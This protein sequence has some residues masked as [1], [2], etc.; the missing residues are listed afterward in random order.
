VLQLQDN[1]H[2]IVQVNLTDMDIV[3]KAM[4]ANTI[5]ITELIH[6][7]LGRNTLTKIKKQAKMSHG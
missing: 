5:L 6:T 7:E 2:L 1:Q 3:N 4:G